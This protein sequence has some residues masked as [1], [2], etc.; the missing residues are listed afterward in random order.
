AVVESRHAPGHPRARA[1]AG[2]VGPPA[3]AVVRCGHGGGPGPAA[4]RSRGAHGGV[5]ED[6]RMLRP[7]PRRLVLVAVLWLA[8]CAAPLRPVGIAAPEV[9]ITL[10]QVNDVYVMEPVDEGR[11]GGLAR[12]AT[13]VKRIRRDNPATLMALAGDLISPSAVSTLLRG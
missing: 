1:G 3:A 2:P 9:R 6:A 7:P 4:H 11:R 12:L 13:L 8:A 5:R 10:L